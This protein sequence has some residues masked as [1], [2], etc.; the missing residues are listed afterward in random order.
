MFLEKQLSLQQCTS[1]SLLLL[2]WSSLKIHHLNNSQQQWVPLR[3]LFHKFCI[4]GMFF[5]FSFPWNME[6]LFWTEGKGIKRGMQNSETQKGWLLSLACKAPSS[7]VAYIT[8]QTPLAGKP[9]KNWLCCKIFGISCFSS[10][11]KIFN[12]SPSHSVLIIL[13]F[14]VMNKTKELE[15]K[16]SKKMHEKKKRDTWTTVSFYL[17]ELN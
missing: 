14:P 1:W 10:D 12:F 11:P 7:L 8:F 13:L 15:C 9:L 3:C 2:W 16:I 6:R 17:T 4:K 5:F